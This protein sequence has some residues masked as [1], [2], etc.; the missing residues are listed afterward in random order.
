MVA[1]LITVHR[2]HLQLFLRAKRAALAGGYLRLQTRYLP[3]LNLQLALLVRM[4]KGNAWKRLCLRAY[5]FHFDSASI[6]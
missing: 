6:A 4:I 5:P 1:M 3:L 2:D